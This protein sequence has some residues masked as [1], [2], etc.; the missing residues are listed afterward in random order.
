MGRAA[1]AGGPVGLIAGR[2]ELPAIAARTLREAGQRVIAAGFDDETR[3]ALAGLVDE[4][5]ALHLGQVERLLAAFRGAG[6]ASALLVGKVHKARTF[7]D[8]RPDLRAL[9]LWMSLPDRRD[10]TILR[11]VVDELAREG[12]VVAEAGRWL[13][14]LFAPA[15]RL[16]RRA[17]DRDERADIAF[18]FRLAREIGRLDVGQTVVVR[19]LAPVAIEALEG[20]DLTIRRGGEVAGP[21]TVVVK[22]AKPAQDMRFDVPVIGLET[23]RAVVAARAAVLAI[24]AGRTLFVQRA[25]TL[26][27]LDAHGVALW[28]CGEA[29]AGA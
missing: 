6:V 8:F 1:D 13:G 16:S 15:G 11:A 3:D 22:T 12:V 24:E 29:D 2:G 5:H 10:D 23:A 25:E 18:G 9:R 28:G 14:P 27:L 17:P 19:H 7:S 21:G 20:T 4:Y 26:A